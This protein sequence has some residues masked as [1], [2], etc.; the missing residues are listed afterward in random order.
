MFKL[1]AVIAIALIDLYTYF[2]LSGVFR[3]P[4]GTVRNAFGVVFWLF[5][6]GMIALF[7]FYFRFDSAERDP[8]GFAR[9]FMVFGIFTLLY[10]PRLVFLGFRITEDLI[11]LG[12]AAV[13]FLASFSGSETRLI[14]LSGISLTG[15]I[16][17]VLPFLAILW[18]LLFGRFNFQVERE[19]LVFPGLPGEFDGLRIV[20]LSDIHLGSIHGKQEKMERAINLINALKPDLVLFTG[21]LVNN[22]T[23]EALGW[24]PLFARIESRYGKFAI[25]GNHDYGDYWE[26]NSDIEKQR[27]LEML[28][29]V[30]KKMGFRLLRNEWDTIRIQSMLLALIGVENWGQPPFKQYGDLDKALSGL[31]DTGFRILLSHDPSHWDAQ[32]LGNP[33]IPLTLSGHTHAM[34]FGLRIGRFSWSPSKYIYKRW[35][36]LYRVNGQSLYVNRG[37]GFIGFPGRI[38]MRPEISLL[39]LKKE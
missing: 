11:W 23:E 33:N 12:S 36:G 20:Q 17:S 14:R 38:G 39:E 31:P 3:L 2:A 27:N 24:E 8:A 30:H 37:L 7:L 22:Y 4:S 9:V 18:G 5:S 6:A 16:I 29:E 10:I 19:K 32:V 13:K 28:E 34:Q 35:M 15:L 25:L 21:D 26:W 1:V